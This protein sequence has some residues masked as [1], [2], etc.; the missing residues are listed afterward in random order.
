VHIEAG[1]SFGFCYLQW[2]LQYVTYFGE[3]FRDV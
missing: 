2:G 3:G 1:Q